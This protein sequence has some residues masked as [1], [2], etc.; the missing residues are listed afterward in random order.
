MSP[1]KKKKPKVILICWSVEAVGFLFVFCLLVL[2][3]ATVVLFN[4]WQSL[5]E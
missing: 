5:H 4:A 3:G 1:P 2:L